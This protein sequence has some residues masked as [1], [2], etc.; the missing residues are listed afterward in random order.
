[1]IN[2]ACE[3]GFPIIAELRRHDASCFLA[4]HRCSHCGAHLFN[5]ELKPG[6]KVIATDNI[7]SQ[8]GQYVIPKGRVVRITGFMS[9]PSLTTGLAF[10]GLLAA[11][12]FSP[13]GFAAVWDI[14]K[15]FGL[16]EA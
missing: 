16:D 14:D 13:E 7:R 11:G 15:M 5:T 1:M 6:E 4:N 12:A 9:L 2:C 8:D 10:C 3:K